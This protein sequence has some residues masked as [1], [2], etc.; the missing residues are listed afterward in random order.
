MRKV[1]FSMILIGIASLCFA[2]TTW[3]FESGSKALGYKVFDS[4]T[5]V[6]KTEKTLHIENEVVQPDTETT[7]QIDSILVSSD[8]YNSD[9]FEVA[10]AIEGGNLEITFSKASEYKNM[11]VEVLPVSE[12]VPM[13]CVRTVHHYAPCAPCP[14]P[15]HSPR[16]GH[17]YNPAPR[18]APH[19]QRPYAPRHHIEPRH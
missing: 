3:K 16:H 17:F 15:M 9:A 1:F 12:V 13:H 11:M 18:P 10:C 2:N 8:A 6:N 14:Q 7:F 5:I 19:S 4:V